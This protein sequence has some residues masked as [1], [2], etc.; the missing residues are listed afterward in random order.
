MQEISS[1]S[2]LSVH[3]S[4]NS[5]S[6]TQLAEIA[7]KFEEDFSLKLKLNEATVNELE[8]GKDEKPLPE[9]EREVE[10]VEEE[11][12]EFS[13]VCLNPNGSPIS[14]DEIFQNG[15]I[16]P[17]FP[18]FNRDI[19]FADGDSESKNSSTIVLRP[20]LRNLFVEE[21]DHGLSTSSSEA[22]E[23]EGPFCVWERKAVE[24]SPNVCKKSNST[25]F[26]KLRRFRELVLRSN[27]D[28]KDAFV[29]LNHHNHNDHPPTL[30]AATASTKPK[31]AEKSEK[32]MEK[33]RKPVAKK[34]EKASSAHER[35]YVSNRAMKEEGKRKSYLPYR[36]GFFTNVNGLSRNLHPY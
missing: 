25:G 14:A 8:N 29:F 22:E 30:T 23:P 7:G 2:V 20:P 26:S 13:F 17:V 9:E 33:K 6:S 24:A 21:R 16:R 5:C 35:L 12:E 28:G 1:S 3:Q 19:L 10:V 36:V 27:S 34:D 4:F 15:Q 31:K 32:A 18:L 11:E